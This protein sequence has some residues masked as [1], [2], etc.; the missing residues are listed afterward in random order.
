[1]TYQLFARNVLEDCRA[2]LAEFERA[3]PAGSLWRVQWVS[4]VVLLR[5]VAEVIGKVDAI[6]K[7][8]PDELREAVNE[9]D[10]HVSGEELVSQRTVT[11]E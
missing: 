3:E 8:H 11:L 6:T 10:Q 7:D 4:N 1:M 2:A 9:C 5:I